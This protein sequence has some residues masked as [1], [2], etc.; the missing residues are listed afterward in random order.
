MKRVYHKVEQIEQ[1]DKTKPTRI[2][3]QQRSAS[4]SELY[5]K[6]IPES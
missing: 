4:T 5:L 6:S 1:I 3:K 2:P